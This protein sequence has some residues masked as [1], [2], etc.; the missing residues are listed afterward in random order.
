MIAKNI[1]DLENILPRE[2]HLEE[3]GYFRSG[4]LDKRKLVQ[5]KVMGDS[6]IFTR[7][8]QIDL[9]PELLLFEGIAI[10]NSGS[11]GDVGTE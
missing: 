3:Q 7:N 9:E 1:R 8:H 10:D 4:K 6:Q 2:Y 11:M 5:W